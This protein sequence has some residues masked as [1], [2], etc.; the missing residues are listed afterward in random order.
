M[1]HGTAGAVERQADV[2][3]RLAGEVLF[4]NLR[5]P[6]EFRLEVTNGRITSLAPVRD[7][8]VAQYVEA[9][10]PGIPLR[11]EI[12]ICTRQFAETPRSLDETAQRHRCVAEPLR[13]MS[14]ARDVRRFPREQRL[15]VAP[16]LHYES[17]TVRDGARAHRLR[18]LG[19]VGPDGSE[20]C[21]E[22]GEI[23]D[24]PLLGGPRRPRDHVALARLET[25]DRLVHERDVDHLR[26]RVKP[27]TQER[28]VHVCS[29]AGFGN[30]PPL[31]RALRPRLLGEYFGA[32]TGE[33][34]YP[35]PRFLEQRAL[36]VPQGTD[37]S[38]ED[39]HDGA[40]L[41][42]DLVEAGNVPAAPVLPSELALV[43][44]DRGVEPLSK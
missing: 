39:A 40:H 7:E 42:N 15:E 5:D 17:A 37:A 29:T 36:V 10:C 12:A 19:F 13:A 4:V 21:P 30:V 24:H 27:R 25:R 23:L 18:D 14:L 28:D 8:V 26:V 6:R 33:Q 41:A 2:D 35:I 20:S 9:L 34:T 44:A 11:E 1:T 22:G 32:F 16:E 43:R 3:A 38:L 31:R